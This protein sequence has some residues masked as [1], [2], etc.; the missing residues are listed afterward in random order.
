MARGQAAMIACSCHVKMS[1]EM[2]YSAQSN[3]RIGWQGQTGLIRSGRVAGGHGENL[4][5]IIFRTGAIQNR[6]VTATGNA[7]HRG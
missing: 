2:A 4:S 1:N 3:R 5:H 7:P 6:A